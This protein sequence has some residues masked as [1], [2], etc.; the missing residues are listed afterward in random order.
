MSPPCA[1]VRGDIAVA[2]KYHGASPDKESGRRATGS[3]NKK[4]GGRVI[5]L[6]GKNPGTP[7]AVKDI[8]PD[9]IVFAMDIGTRTV[10]GVIGRQEGDVF[11]VLA[12]EV[13]EHKSR[14]MMD[15][16]VHDIDQTAVTAMEVKRR[17]EERMGF[18]LKRVAIAA[19]GR[20][21]RTCQ[22]KVEKNLEQDMEIDDDLVSS[23]EIEGIQRAQTVLDENSEAEDKNQYY[24]VGYSVINYYLNGYVITKLTGH[25]GRTAGVELLATFLPLTVVD[26]L[27]SV[28]NR[29]GLEVASLTLEPIAA[30]NVA[31]APDL[32][33]LNLAL[34]DIGAGTSDIA[35]T[36]DGSVFAY[37]M[38]SVAGDEITESISQRYLVDFATAEK[39]KV[40]LSSGKEKIRF[41]DILKKKHEIT[42]E[43]VLRDIGDT[44]RML[45]SAISG[46]IL[47]YNR[48]APNAVFLVGG[49]SRIPLLTKFLA[50]QLGLPEDRVV[51]RG[52]DVVRGVKYSD[53]KLFGPEAVTPLGIAVTAQ[54][55]AG[56]DFLSVTVN[57]KKLKLFNSKKLKVSDALVLYGF[58]GGDLIGRSGKSI[59]CT[60]NGEERRIRGEYGKAAEI[61]LN[62][63][64]SSLDASLSF[65]DNITV[66]PAQNGRDASVKAY[67]LVPDYCTGSVILNGSPVDISTIITVNGRQV[68]AETEIK[69]GD[70]VQFSRIRTLGDLLEAAGFTGMDCNITVNGISDCRYDY[71]LKDRDVVI[72]EERRE[73][74]SPA[75]SED[76]GGSVGNL[77]KNGAETEAG[78]GTGTEAETG[79]MMNI[80]TRQEPDEWFDVTV[81]G[82][83]VSLRKNQARHM[84]VDIFNYID[85]DLSKPQG[86]IVLR[87]NG[88]P[89]A[90]TDVIG[91][92][93]E[94]EIYWRK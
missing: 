92:G 19:A 4:R 78:I 47:E 13:C 57:D 35:L 27:Y 25:K 86:T 69:D 79:D 93:D 77:H 82:K 1:C 15:G 37:A 20:V 12:T 49:G 53:K 9:D 87:L 7:A 16:Q 73:D 23:I 70:T 3:A 22:V 54:M 58:N 65:G 36:K 48:K 18:R 84:F 10:A 29:L 63:K 55:Y 45:A 31:I 91:E 5:M 59:T 80:Y 75:A 71:V 46:K 11:H 24:C 81:N 30:I 64:L 83:T 38:A 94:I 40:S 68:G 2:G 44:I 8:A 88:R 56:K 41:T 76:H 90:F 60:V 32:R 51:V 74:Y 50:E 34:V 67:E 42:A 21:L 28:V 89:A 43:E 39:I 26:S 72:C 61:W 66:I 6:E 62:G 52:R 85:F 33:L 17:L 14:A